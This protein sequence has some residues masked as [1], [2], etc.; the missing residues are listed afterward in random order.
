MWI[1]EFIKLNVHKLKTKYDNIENGCSKFYTLMQIM[2]PILSGQ[3]PEMNE[4]TGFV[5]CVCAWFFCLSIA[6]F[7]LKFKKNSHANRN[8]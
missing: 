4:W 2:L 5:V 8:V 3:Y 6:Y 1:D 7:R